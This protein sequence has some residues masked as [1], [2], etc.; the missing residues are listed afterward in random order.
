MRQ[1][2]LIVCERRD[3][4]TQ[5]LRGALVRRGIDRTELTGRRTWLRQRSGIAAV[6]C[7]LAEIPASLIVVE[8]TPTNL[9]ELLALLA[10]LPMRWPDARAVAVIDEQTAICRHGLREAG[11]IHIVQE[12]RELEAVAEMALAHFARQPKPALTLREEI[13]ESLPWKP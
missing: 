12:M 10:E 2:D 7:L 11:A 3:R 8:T 5:T 4:L 1:A 6:L 13:W 9:K